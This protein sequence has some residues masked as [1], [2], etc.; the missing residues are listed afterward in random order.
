MDRNLI[1]LKIPPSV[2]HMYFNRYFNNRII[3]SL[4]TTAQIWFKN[5][6]IL[7][8][9]WKSKNKWVTVDSKIIV[10]IWFYFPD[11]RKRDTHN[12]LK[13]LMDVLEKAEIYTD[14]KYAMPRIIDYQI[15]RQYPRI[16]ISFEIYNK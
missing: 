7:I 4:S 9:D 10:N 3:K 12:G 16:E 5:S 11:N 8:H 13:I 15:D 2:N 14:D 6:I 1:I